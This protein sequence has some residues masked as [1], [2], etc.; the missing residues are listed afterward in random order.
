MMD[1]A[2]KLTIVLLYFAVDA[3]LGVLSR[4]GFLKD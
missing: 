4:L 3:A 1:D 2:R